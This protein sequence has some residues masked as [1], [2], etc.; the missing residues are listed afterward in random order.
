MNLNNSQWLLWLKG[1]V[2]ILIKIIFGVISMVVLFIFGVLPLA[3]TVFYFSFS[4]VGDAL[5]LLV[6]GGWDK[7]KVVPVK[8]GVFFKKISTFKPKAIEMR[9]MTVGELRPLVLRLVR[10]L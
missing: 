3:F 2:L 9:W 8:S 1:F 6:E 7:A 5:T 10:I 4:A